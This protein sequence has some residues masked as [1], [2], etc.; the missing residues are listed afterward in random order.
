VERG[1]ILHTADE[2]GVPF[3]ELEDAMGGSQSFVANNAA[4]ATCVHPFND[5][6]VIAGQS[7][8]A[9][10]IYF[11]LR[12]RGIDPRAQPN[13]LFAG[14]GGVGKAAGNAK[15][16]KTMVGL[17]LMHPG[18]RVVAVQEENCNAVGRAL[19][20][21][22]RGNTD[23]AN[24]FADADG[25]NTFNPWV[26]GTAVLTP[27]EESLALAE[28]LQQEGYLTM[29]TVTEAE[30]AEELYNY[31]QLEPAGALARAGRRKVTRQNARL[32]AADDDESVRQ[33][34]VRVAINSGGNISQETRDHF[35]A[36]YQAHQKQRGKA[37]CRAMQGAVLQ[38]GPTPVKSQGLALSRDAQQAVM[39]AYKDQLADL[40]IG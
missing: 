13:E 12:A 14:A 16:I 17:G 22:A 21:R 18:S 7:T 3:E 2:N 27:G 28:K 31:R 9:V 6:E 34:I 40:N 15:A 39:S 25:T 4:E 37:P 19:E 30:L 32:W 5:P 8:I 36:V 24:L 10:E 33:D 38:D 1:A 20:R 35:D 23:L 29:M 11:Q 26:D